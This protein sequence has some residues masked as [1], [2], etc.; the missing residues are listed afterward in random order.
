VDWPGPVCFSWR[1]ML[2]P[3]HLQERRDEIAESCRRRGVEAD[4]DAAIAA[5]E[6][7]AEAQTAVNEANRLRNEHQKSGQR[8][9]DDAEREA[10]TAEGRRLKDEVGRHEAALAAARA[11]L[12]AALDPIPNFI[13]AD[14]PVG[15]E[16]D[17]RFDLHRR[18][19]GVL[20]ASSLVNKSLTIPNGQRSLL[21]EARRFAG[22]MAQASA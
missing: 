1:A 21:A 20:M 2:D 14:V 16:A 19:D 18:L 13:H 9:M 15:G 11:D 17:F 22:S 10:H 12:D 6:R 7:V 4:L 8:K 5:Q 3:R